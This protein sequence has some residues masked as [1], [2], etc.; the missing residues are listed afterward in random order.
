MSQALSVTLAASAT[1]V[2]SGNGSDVDI[3]ALRRA[4]KLTARVTGYT[5]IDSDP[6]PSVLLTVQTRSTSSLPWRT[7][8]TLSVTATGLYE[9][10]LGGLDQIVRVT[11]TLTNMTNATFEVLGEAHVV[12]CDPADIVGDAVPADS[13]EDITASERAR[14]CISV[15]EEVDGY[16]NAA[17]EMPITAWGND[18]RSKS[19]EMVA[20]K[21][22]RHRGFDPDSAADKLVLEREAAAVKWLEKVAAG[23]LRPPGIVDSAPTVF[24]GGSYATVQANRGW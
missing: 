24:E 11:W 15:T 23:K 7:A 2:A 5:V 17:Y 22:F 1:V 14:A 19:A 10:S 18:L 21:L 3:G 16:L 13:I 8:D 4:L 20:A 9:L 6:T 12:Y